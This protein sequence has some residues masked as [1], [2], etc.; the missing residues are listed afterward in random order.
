MNDEKCLRKGQPPHRI[1]KKEEGAASNK[2]LVRKLSLGAAE[3][4][5]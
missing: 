3:K 2:H 1:G 4:G 5:D